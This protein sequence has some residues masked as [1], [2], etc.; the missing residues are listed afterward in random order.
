MKHKHLHLSED[1]SEALETAAK[2]ERRSQSSLVDE[3]LR[4][5]LS[6]RLRRT[7]DTIPAS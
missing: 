2:H 6:Y 1:V 7:V 3:L 4:E 5:A